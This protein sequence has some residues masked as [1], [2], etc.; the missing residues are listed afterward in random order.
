MGWSGRKIEENQRTRGWG[1][2]ICTK[3]R[4]DKKQIPV[5]TGQ[6]EDFR[7]EPRLFKL[8]LEKKFLNIGLQSNKN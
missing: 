1:E 2:Q 5:E 7:E 8:H 6:V 3:G 4:K